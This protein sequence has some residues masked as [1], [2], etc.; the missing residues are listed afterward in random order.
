[1]HTENKNVLYAT[2]SAQPQKVTEMAKQY[3]YYQCDIYSTVGKKLQKFWD[4][5]IRAAH[6]ADAYAKKYGAVSYIQPVQF[7]EGGVDYL[8]FDHQPDPEVWRKRVRSADGHDEYE[9]NCMVRSDILVIPDDRFRP[10]DTWNKTY[11]K[12]HLRWEQVRQQKTVK[13]WAAII[14]YELTGDREKDTSN[15]EQ[16]LSKRSFV[17]FLEY[18]GTQQVAGRSEAPQS[19]RKAIRAEKDRLALP[20]VETEWLF[21]LLDM[22]RPTDANELKAWVRNMETPIFFTYADSFYIRSQCPCRGEGL[23]PT[24]EGVFVYKQ[25][26][27]T[28]Q[29]K[30]E[31]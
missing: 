22:E 15:I 25:N 14:G 29:A 23:Y 24:T 28:Q 30:H 9:P 1:M 10:S 31:N 8:E 16:Q 13:E 3:Y 11:S 2:L 21:A 18:Y 5:V 19:L 26:V 27:A 6:R 17:P 4:K 12:E 7:F 20:V